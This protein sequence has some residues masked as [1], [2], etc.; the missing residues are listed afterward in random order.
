[1]APLER[2]SVWIA[3]ALTFLT[4]VGYMWTKYFVESGDPWAAVNHPLEPW[5][6]RAHVVT[7][8]LLVFVL[9]VIA[10]R[11][12]WRHFRS[13]TPSGR[14]SGVLVALA[15]V[16]MVLTGYVIQVV[17]HQ[18]WLRALAISHIGVGFLYALGLVLHEFALAKASKPAEDGV[19]R[20][21]EPRAWAAGAGG[22]RPPRSRDA[23]GV[24]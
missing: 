23:A 18:G 3:S 12:V 1:M 20:R 19:P 8:P 7:A 17:T 21:E 10:S 9:G 11:H 13:G 5:F 22:G 4:G 6:L 2:W 16:P 15:V 24:S 14:R